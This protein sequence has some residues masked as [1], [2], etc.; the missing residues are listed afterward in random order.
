MNPYKADIVWLGSHFHG[1]PTLK[2]G[3][4]GYTGFAIANMGVAETKVQSVDIFGLAANLRLAYKYGKNRNDYLALDGVFTTGDD[5]NISDGKYSG[6]LT[7][8]NWTAPGAVFFSH[9][10]YLLLPHGNVVNRFTG[11]CN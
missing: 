11:C 5:N 3:R 9:G 10:L 6:V 2:Q 1:N 4:F 7:G 8:N